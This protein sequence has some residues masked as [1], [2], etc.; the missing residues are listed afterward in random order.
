MLRALAQP[1]DDGVGKRNCP[2]LQLRNLL[3]EDVAG[4]D[5]L[6]QRRQPRIV[7]T[8]C[9]IALTDVDEHHDGGEQKSAR[10]GNTLSGDIRR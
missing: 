9:H 3:V 4:V 2:D 5:A 7:D 6:F 8:R 10:V 1:S